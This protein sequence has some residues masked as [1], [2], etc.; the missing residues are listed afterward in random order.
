MTTGAYSASHRRSGG[1]TNV[2]NELTQH[3]HSRGV[4]PFSVAAAFCIGLALVGCS[5]SPSRVDA[6]LPTG[7]KPASSA[8]Q[9][10]PSS[11][12]GGSYTSDCATTTPPPLEGAAPPDDRV[13]VKVSLSKVVLRQGDTAAGTVTITNR[14]SDRIDISHPS[15][16]AIWYGLYR[17]GSFVG[18]VPSTVTRPRSRTRSSQAQARVGRLP[19]TPTSGPTLKA[20][21]LSRVRTLPPLASIQGPSLDATSIESGSRHLALHLKSRGESGSEASHDRTPLAG[22]A[23]SVH[24]CSGDP[25]ARVAGRCSRCG[26]DGHAPRRAG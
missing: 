10:S 14:S 25:H 18:A 5:G 4:A 3:Q 2:S 26:T 19:L 22:G 24:A 13:C 15:G 11:A 23:H 20:R 21:I 12:K 7:E 6:G 17:D 9:P 16:C 8:S 1:A